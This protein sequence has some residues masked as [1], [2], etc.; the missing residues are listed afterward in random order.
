MAQPSHAPQPV[1]HLLLA[2]A[3]GLVGG[4]AL[5]LALAA[6]Q[7][8]TV[9]AL[10][11]RPLTGVADARLQMHRVDFAALPATA[12]AP[13]PDA[14]LCALGTTIRQAGSQ[15]AFRAVDHDAVLAFAAAAQQ[16]GVQRLAVVSALGA[17]ARSPVFY[18]RVK[19]ETEAALQAMGFRCLVIARPSLLAGDRS[20]LGQP[21]RAGERIGLAISRPLGALIPARWRPVEAAVVARALLRALADAAPGVQVMESDE[22]QRRGRA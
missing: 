17:D 14:A 13:A 2:G 9:H 5:R 19:G 10:V 8:R 6:P 20:A 11:R 15:A 3:S 22:L 12:L 4:A 21:E 1:H 7:T 16:A 18:N